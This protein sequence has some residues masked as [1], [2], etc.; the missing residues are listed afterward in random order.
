M[1][2]RAITGDRLCGS[3]PSAR[4]PR[5]A[6]FAAPVS[7]IARAAATA[8][9]TLLIVG[10]LRYRKARTFIVCA[11]ALLTCS[12]AACASRSLPP[13]PA[14][15]DARAADV[16]SGQTPPPSPAPGAHA[17]FAPRSAVKTP[18]HGLIDLGQV[19]ADDMPEPPSNTL[20]YVCRRQAAISGIVVNETWEHMQRNGGRTIDTS[21]VDAALTAIAA[22]NATP[23]VEE[24]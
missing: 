22:Y 15:S 19:I 9:R 20:Y 1:P 21:S 14:S 6:S 23:P 24:V 11:A 5:T 12:V 17:A 10:Y 18:I 7:A 16:C 3:H 13:A 8:A 4:S 2:L